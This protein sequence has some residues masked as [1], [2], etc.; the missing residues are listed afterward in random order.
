[1]KSEA[2]RSSVEMERRDAQVMHSNERG[3]VDLNGL[4]DQENSYSHHPRRRSRNFF[5]N[6]S[7]AYNTILCENTSNAN[8]ETNKANNHDF[9]QSTTKSASRLSRDRGKG[10]GNRVNSTDNEN[11]SFHYSAEKLRRDFTVSTVHEVKSLGS[12]NRSCS[13][14][15]ELWQSTNAS[16]FHAKPFSNIN[17]TIHRQQQ[18]QQ[19][20]FM[21]ETLK[22]SNDFEEK[23]FNKNLKQNLDRDEF[24]KV[25]APLVSPP[26]NQP[27][28]S[29]EFSGYEILMDD[30]GTLNVVDPS[31]S[32]DDGWI[33]NTPLKVSNRSEVSRIL[34]LLPK[35]E[36]KNPTTTSC[37]QE[38]SSLQ[39]YRFTCEDPVAATLLNASQ[40]SSSNDD[41]SH[42]RSVSTDSAWSIDCSLDSV[43]SSTGIRCI[44]DC[45]CDVKSEDEVATL[46]RPI[47]VPPRPMT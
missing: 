24:G 17:N 32:K 2:K 14:N 47:A 27:N 9:K 29:S 36:T 23:L 37:Q 39:A 45:L 30:L 33:M 44:S 43:C 6:S 26:N 46:Y 8:D 42:H 15:H 13:H 3:V 40:E 5:R 21:K 10:S 1:M 20:Q 18:Q 34:Q 7:S 22:G 12:E 38:K 28:R 16:N 35:E 31:N 19:Q 4:D 25:D 11:T 41:K